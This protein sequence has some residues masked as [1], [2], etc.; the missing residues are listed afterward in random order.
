MFKRKL[1]IKESNILIRKLKKKRITLPR[2]GKNNNKSIN[3]WQGKYRYNGINK[4]DQQ[5]W[6]RST[7]LRAQFENIRTEKMMARPIN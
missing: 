1:R 2:I 6:Y 7:K 5:S 3:K 4:V